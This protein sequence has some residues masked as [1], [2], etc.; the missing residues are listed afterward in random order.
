MYSIIKATRK[1]QIHKNTSKSI[2]CWSIHFISSVVYDL[3]HEHFSL[4]VGIAVRVVAS[5]VAS[6]F[7]SFPLMYVAQ[8]ILCSWEYV[9]SENNLAKHAII[10]NKNIRLYSDRGILIW[11]YPIPLN[12]AYPIHCDF[13]LSC[14]CTT[15]PY[16]YGNDSVT[17]LVWLPNRYPR[18]LY[19]YTKTC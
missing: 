14:Q 16:V 11:C 7:T 17:M 19:N 3:Q 1:L 13:G 6:I 12:T 2:E 4:A 9:C 15:D 18:A 10:L 8:C 5:M